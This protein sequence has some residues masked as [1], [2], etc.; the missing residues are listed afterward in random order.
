MKP[1]AESERRMAEGAELK[2]QDGKSTP[3]TVQLQTSR[4]QKAR[5]MAEGV[6]N[7]SHKME[8]Q[9]SDR[10]ASDLES[11]EAEGVCHVVNSRVCGKLR[12]GTKDLLPA[13]T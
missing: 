9:T 2:P 13:P 3:Q 10:A 1:K 4:R 7:L 5:R 12:L 11:F 8:S 6:Q